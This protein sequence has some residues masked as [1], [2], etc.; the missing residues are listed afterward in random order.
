MNWAYCRALIV[1]VLPLW[2]A[3][4]VAHGLLPDRAAS[5]DDYVRPTAIPFPDENSY[6]ETKAGLG[7]MLFFDPILSGSRSRSCAT[8]HNPSLSW[9]DG[10]ARAIGEG[11]AAMALRSPTLLNVAWVP[12][13]G[14]D[15]KFRDLESVAIGPITSPANMNLPEPVLIERLAAIPGYIRSFAAAFGEG[16]IT[17]RNI[18]AALATYERPIVSGTAPFDRWV[19]GDEQ[20]ID[21]S[22]KRGF[23]IFTGKG[24][25]SECHSGWA[26]TDGSFHDIGT[27][28]GD[29]IGRG[30]L[31]P[32]SIKLRYAFKTPTL[33]DVARRAPYMHNGSL[34]TLQD[35]V[36]LYDRGGVARPSRSGLIGPLRLTENEKSDLVAFLQTLTS[37]PQPVLLPVLP[38]LGDNLARPRAELNRVTDQSEISAHP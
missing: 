18:E 2:A 13:L 22:A 9:G 34:A 29:D 5:R 28:Q 33:R 32:T 35:V 23:D 16:P 6:S 19:M 15:G 10:L 21:Q 30:R 38:R 11:Q 17:R 8:C 20:A 1:L 27:A 31:F 37:P 36:A 26:F 25:C 7:R 24:R 14:W 4:S 3:G 12:R